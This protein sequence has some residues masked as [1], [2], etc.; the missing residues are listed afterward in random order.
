MV[1]TSWLPS[2]VE[3]TRARPSEPREITGASP[4]WS[5]DRA[6]CRLLCRLDALAVLRRASQPPTNRQHGQRDPGARRRAPAAGA[7]IV[8]WGARLRGRVRPGTRR[9]WQQVRLSHSRGQRHQQG[10]STSEAGGVEHPARVARCLPEHP[11]RAAPASGVVDALSRTVEVVWRR[12]RCPFLRSAAGFWSLSRCRCPAGV[13]ASVSPP[14]PHPIAPCPTT[15]PA[16]G[17][18]SWSRPRAGHPAARPSAPPPAGRGPS[19]GVG[20]GRSG[21]VQKGCPRGVKRGRF[22]SVRGGVTPRKCRK[23]SNLAGFWGIRK[24]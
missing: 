13:R 24:P 7:P 11:A 16:P 4:V 22:R 20:R 1:S 2:R 23:T 3:P 8:W 17:A 12:C 10:E 21:R 19:A 6:R 14:L 15:S 5:P 9:S 18:P